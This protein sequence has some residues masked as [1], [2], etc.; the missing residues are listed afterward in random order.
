DVTKEYYI[1][2]AGVQVGVLCDSAFLRYKEALG[3]DIGEIPAGL[4]PGEYLIEVG[5]KFA[6]IHGDK[7]LSDSQYP[8]EIRQFTIDEMMILIKKDLADLGVTHD[9]FSSEQKLHD[10]NKIE[11]AVKY[12]ESKGLLY[13][14]VL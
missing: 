2:D 12:L 10:G 8:M 7:F 4:Y 9:I 6:K 1:N 14:G 3:Q 13:R 11:E 5:Q